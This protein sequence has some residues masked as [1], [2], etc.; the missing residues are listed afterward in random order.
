C[1]PAGST[2]RGVLALEEQGLR[3][4]VIHAVRAA[5]SSS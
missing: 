5:L 3:R 1:S 4:A 2:I